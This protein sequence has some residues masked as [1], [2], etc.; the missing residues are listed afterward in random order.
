M[1][2]SGE[3]TIDALLRLHA[4]IRPTQTAIVSARAGDHVAEVSFADLDR[5]A[6]RFARALEGLGVVPGEAVAFVLPNGLEFCVA[7]LGIARLG[8]VAMPLGSASTEYELTY[9]LQDSGARFMIT[10]PGYRDTVLGAMERGARVQTALVLEPAGDPERVAWRVLVQKAGDAYP[11]T[12]L[13]GQALPDRTSPAMLLYTSGST[14]RPKGILMSHEAIVMAGTANAWHQALRPDDRHGIVLPMYHINALALQFLAALTVGAS[15]Y[16]GRRFDPKTFW[17]EINAAGVTVG[18]L[19]ATGIRSLVR[20]DLDSVAGRMRLMM[21]G[22]PVPDAELAEFE[23]RFQCPLVMV[24]GLTET[25]GCGTRSPLYL[26]RK[27]NCIGRPMPGWEVRILDDDRQDCPPLVQ[28]EVWLRGPS[29]MVGYLNNPEETQRVIWNGGILTGD[30]AV[31]DADGYVQFV[32]RKKDLIKVKGRSVASLEVEAVLREHPAVAEVAVLGLPDPETDERI[33]AVAVAA[34]SVTG[35]ELIR[36]CSERL[37][38]YKVPREVR[39]QAELP[40]TSV[41][42]TRKSELKAS[43]LKQSPDP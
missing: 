3:S 36:F 31:F 10:T 41:G 34:R 25:C 37:A 13:H 38:W 16:F 29:Q 28:G 27:A 20:E 39:F 30:T 8:C 32:D 33:V 6:A 9:M 17:S 21:Y 42:K 40:K 7:L 22:L 18:N 24:Y 5:L 12:R 1:F 14:A 4:R 19:V 35:E 11:P 43:I 15:V 26:D 2:T 23:R